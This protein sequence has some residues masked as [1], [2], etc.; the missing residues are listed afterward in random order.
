MCRSHVKEPWPG[1]M[2]TESTSI[3]SYL[4]E[5]APSIHTQFVRTFGANIVSI[6]NYSIGG[7]AGGH[8]PNNRAG[9][10]GYHNIPPGFPRLNYLQPSRGLES[11]T[12][13]I[14]HSLLLL[15]ST[16]SSFLSIRSAY[17]VI[18]CQLRNVELS[19]PYIRWKYGEPS[20]RFKN[21]SP[22]AL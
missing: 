8:I 13:F 18:V 3:L 20:G 10:P 7:P 19:Y 6:L 9:L 14:T 21:Q 2:A 22:T 12:G 1:P 15:G 11:S 16:S 4:R 17:T 5:L